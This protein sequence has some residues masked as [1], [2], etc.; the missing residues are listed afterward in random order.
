MLLT[1]NLFD[2][3]P[4]KTV[5]IYL[6]KNISIFVLNFKCTQCHVRSLHKKIIETSFQNKQQI[7]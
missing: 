3:T 7:L 2:A 1:D 4:P 5:K 6:L